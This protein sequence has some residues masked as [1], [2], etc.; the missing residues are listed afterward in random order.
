MMPARALLVALH[1]FAGMD[2][3]FGRELPQLDSLKALAASLLKRKDLGSADAYCESYG[4]AQVN[5]CSGEK[6]A[7][8]RVLIRRNGKVTR[9]QY[10]SWREAA[11]PALGE[12]RGAYP[13]QEWRLL[14]ETI[15]AMRWTDK[16]GM[17]DPGIPPGPT[18][19][20][21]VLTL[22][23]G[24]R[25]ASFSVSG[26]APVPI[27]AGM[28]KAGQ[29]GDSASDT[30]WSLA[31]ASPKIGIRKGKLVLEAEWIARGTVPVTLAW[32][33]SS[34]PHGCGRAMLEWSGG[35]ESESGTHTVS[36]QRAKGT[37]SAWTLRPG[38]KV[39]V[40][41]QFPYAQPEPGKKTGKLREFGVLAQVA[42]GGEKIPLTFFSDRIKF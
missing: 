25:T 6:R 38:H 41:L 22:S 34:E 37:K 20:I 31:L 3:A 14:L 9:Y 33:D 35:E 23:D 1:L 10:R 5:S 7:N 24:S 27:G 29:L 8:A 26:P 13:E 2:S 32:P 4:L 19:T 42:G 39:P 36:A 16:P 15:A 28:D 17:P 30:V 11:D 21:Q 12:F 40:Q 18:Q